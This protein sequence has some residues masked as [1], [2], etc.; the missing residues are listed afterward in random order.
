MKQAAECRRLVV[1][2]ADPIEARK[3]DREAARIAADKAMT[4][5]QC[6]KTFMMSVLRSGLAQQRPPKRQW[7]KRARRSMSIPVIGALPVQIVDTSWC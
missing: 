3:N 4:F 2:G 6:A 1:D 7:R 5:E